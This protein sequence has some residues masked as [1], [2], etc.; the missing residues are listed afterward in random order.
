M[1]AGAAN[2]TSGSSCRDVQ[3]FYTMKFDRPLIDQD[4][5]VSSSLLDCDIKISFDLTMSRT[6]DQMMADI[7]LV[8]PQILSL[9]HTIYHLPIN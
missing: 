4:L 7:S 5:S 1:A 9:F 8:T 2:S 6:T 3:V